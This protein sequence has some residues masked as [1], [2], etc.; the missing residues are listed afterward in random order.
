MLNKLFKVVAPVASSPLNARLARW[1][2][3]HA[4][5]LLAATAT[6][7]ATD[8]LWPVA[9]VGAASFVGFAV[10]F[11]HH[12]TPT[13]AF[14]AANTLTACRLGGLLALALWPM[15]TL[16]IAGG[17]A[18]LLLLDG[19]DGWLARRFDQASDFGAFFDKEVDA[20]A[21]LVLCLLAVQ[22]QGIAPLLITAGLLR[23]V[24][25]VLMHLGNPPAR[26]EPRT[27]AAR[28]LYVFMMGA[29]LLPFLP[30]PA[31]SQV[32][33]WTAVAGL[34]ASFLPYFAWALRLPQ[35]LAGLRRA[36]S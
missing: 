29:V 10:A 6:A 4:V 9:L 13:G 30:L 33:L 21:L 35:R 8:A 11:R 23:Y 24:F 5:L 2:A 7:L 28:Y 25:A 26:T 12:W 32:V 14:G 27:N 1:A 3:L 19:A 16:W 18:A 15:P 22:Y 20:F 36:L 17:A 34:V 31:W